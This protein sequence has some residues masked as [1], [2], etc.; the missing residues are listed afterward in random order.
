MELKFYKYHGAGNDFVIID[1]RNKIFNAEDHK[2]IE[3]ICHRRFGV[4]ADGLMLLENE[5]D[6]IS[7]WF[8]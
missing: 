1:N 6:M 2:L 4:G 3:A 8:I 7:E 5:A